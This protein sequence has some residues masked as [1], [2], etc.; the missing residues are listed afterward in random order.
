MTK[1]SRMAA[2]A[3]AATWLLL[4]GT[5]A[6]AVEFSI[7]GGFDRDT[8]GNTPHALTLD[9]QGNLWGVLQN[10]YYDYDT[11]NSTNGAVFKYSAANGVQIV[12]ELID[13]QQGSNPTGRLLLASDGNFYGATIN[14][15]SSAFRMT[16]SGQYTPL[17]PSGGPA[18]GGL[19]EGSDGAIY[20]QT[21]HGGQVAFDGGTLFKYQ[22]GSFTTVA[23]I[24]TIGGRQPRGGVAIDAAGNV[25][26]STTGNNSGSGAI[27]YRY[28]A[29]GQLTNLASITGGFTGENGGPA[30][31]PDGNVYGLI[32][33]HGGSGS[34]YKYDVTSN[35]LSTFFDF[36]GTG[37]SGPTGQVIF[38]AN[39]TMWGV[40]QGN[41]QVQQGG[42]FS[43]TSGGVFTTVHS[44]QYG[45]P[46]Y[47]QPY[48]PAGGLTA[49]AQ[50]NLFGVTQGGGTGYNGGAIFKIANAGFAV[51]GIESAVPE[52]ASWAMLVLGFGLIG[53]R[54][55]RRGTPVVTA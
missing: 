42:V 13:Y 25:Y 12:K 1:I 36:S 14:G 24:G 45:P 9:A 19:S 2:T 35:A 26:G 51:G 6:A 48:Y 18:Y 41:N 34:V 46:N 31:G 15:S 10:G 11:Y 7:L 53:A 37:L 22:N 52:P 5:G 44:F 33:S 30:I 3:G 4:A 20:G 28:S 39:G 29:S 17:G 32:F 50:G 8:Q 40:A 27:L 38:D 47:D 16:A 43:L 55:R 23:D 49:D 21:I 54:L